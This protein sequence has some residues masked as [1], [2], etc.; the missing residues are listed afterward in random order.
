MRTL[1]I[2][3]DRCGDRFERDVSKNAH[4]EQQAWPGVEVTISTSSETGTRD[5]TALNRVYDLCEACANLLDD[6]IAEFTS[7]Q[8]TKEAIIR[9]DGERQRMTAPPLEDTEVLAAGNWTNNAEMIADLARLGWLNGRILDATYGEG[10]FWTEYRPDELTTNDLHKPADWGIDIRRPAEVWFASFDTVVVDSPYKLGGTPSDQMAKMNTAY[11]VEKARTRDETL[12]LLADM[13]RG[14]SFCV[15]P[16][17]YLMVKCQNQ[18]NSGRFTD[19]VSLVVAAVPDR[20]ELAS[21][22]Y[23]RTRPM[24][25]PGGREQRTP[26]NNVSQLVVFRANEAAKVKQ[27]ES[28]F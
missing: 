16:G 15:K 28:L 24:P 18:I 23:L 9:W 2:R 1:T 25:Q 17:G 19:Q 10:K 6:T 12:K 7:T 4:P 14:A 11:G 13:T 3:C 26:R 20:F 22:L 21:I 5:L 27:E 8:V